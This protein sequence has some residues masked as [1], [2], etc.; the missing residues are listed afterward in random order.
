MMLA[1]VTLL[2]ALTAPQTDVTGKWEG[3]L[4]ATRPDGSAVSEPLLLIL[5]QKEKNVA[6]SVGRDESDRH[7]V[8]AGTIDG[9]KIVLTAKNAR[10]E[11]EYHLQLT[12]ENDELKGTVE[13]GGMTAKVETK[14]KSK[15]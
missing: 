7:P 1:M 9:S 14:R 6:G 10:N 15:E 3:T 13:S 4:S 2:L 8:T 11:R 12:L 5:E